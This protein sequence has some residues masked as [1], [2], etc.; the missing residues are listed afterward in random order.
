MAGNKEHFI[1]IALILAVHFSRFYA[2]PARHITV[3]ALIFGI[4]PL[5][6]T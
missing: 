1:I 2:Y 6:P 5:S 3:V 4:N